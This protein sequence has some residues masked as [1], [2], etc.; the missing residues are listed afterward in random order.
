MFFFNIEKRV[1]K[2]FNFPDVHSSRPTKL[3]EKKRQ[4]RQYCRKLIQIIRY[5][6]KKIA[7]NTFIVHILSGI[8]VR[9]F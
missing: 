2:R 6:S 4:L 1:Y 5:L 3:L 7:T 9:H 8:T